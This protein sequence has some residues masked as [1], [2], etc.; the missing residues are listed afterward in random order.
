MTKPDF[1]SNT[2]ARHK[3]EEIEKL[4]GIIDKG[5]KECRNSDKF[6]DYLKMQSKLPRYSVNNT[7]LIM[8]QS[9]GRA[10]QVASYTTWKSLGRQVIRGEKGMQIFCPTPYKKEVEVERRS[11]EGQIIKEKSEELRMGYKP[12]YVFDVS[13]TTG[14]ELP[15][16]VKILQGDVQ[17][18]N[19]LM[20]A[21]RSVSPVPIVFERIEGSANG[22][23]SSRER[24]IGVS[25]ELSPLQ[26]V[27][28]TLHELGH[29]YLDVTG[30]DKERSR[31]ERET[32][33]EAISFILTNRLLS[34][35]VTAADVGEYSFGYLATWGDDNL[36]EFKTCLDTIQK[37]SSALITNIEK[38]LRQIVM[39]REIKEAAKMVSQDSHTI[40]I[41]EHNKGHGLHV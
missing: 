28:T 20:S 25:A 27:K 2:Y 13:Q 10:S 19:D 41:D 36:S 38:S 15:A 23:Y 4:S 35:Q 3:K 26:Q 18:Y 39:D 12:G 29:A 7:L 22:Y 32:E 30:Q 31:A 5:I 17:G 24:K 9:K 33:A 6:K 8:M 37:S 21:I 16:P 40:H 11:A 14:A 1:D 34:D